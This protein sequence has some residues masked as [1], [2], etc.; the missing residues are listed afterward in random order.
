MGI[1]PRGQQI[2][3]AT[4]MQESNLYNLPPRRRPRLARPVPAAAE[5]RLGFAEAADQPDLRRA[6]VLR[7]LVHYQGA[8][9]TLT[10]A[11]QG[12]QRSAFPNAYA[13]HTSAACGSSGLSTRGSDPAF[14]SPRDDARHPRTTGG[15]GHRHMSVR[16]LPRT[17]TATR[18]RHPLRHRVEVEAVAALRPAVRHPA[19]RPGHRVDQAE[20]DAERRRTRRAPPCCRR[21]TTNTPSP[22]RS[23][24]AMS[25]RS[26]HHRPP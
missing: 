15:G 19:L 7:V 13:K 2:A 11:A 6:R 22:C 24:T 12:V 20:H 14:D 4:A 5:L 18:A 21:R 9:G 23:G 1:S 16:E 26:S 10:R 17:A 8:W 3:I 25:C